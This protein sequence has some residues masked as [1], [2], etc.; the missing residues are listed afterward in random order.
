MRGP[1]NDPMDL[2]AYCRQCNTIGSLRFVTPLQ[3]ASYSVEQLTRLN[4]V[5]ANDADALR[6]PHTKC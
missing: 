3:L 2:K 1:S 5:D 6:E 4:L